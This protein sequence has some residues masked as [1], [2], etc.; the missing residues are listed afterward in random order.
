MRP[1]RFSTAKRTSRLVTTKGF[2]LAPGAQ[3]VFSPTIGAL[4][5]GFRWSCNVRV[6]ANE[7]L[8]ESTGNVFI[9]DPTVPSAF[10]VA[11]GKCFNFVGSFGRH[12]ASFAYDGMTVDISKFTFTYLVI[13]RL[14]TRV[15]LHHGMVELQKGHEYSEKDTQ[16]RFE[17]GYK[18]M[19]NQYD[20]QRTSSDHKCK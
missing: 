6:I 3:G 8:P 15:L 5:P 1:N 11:V 17:D 19:L 2:L 14:S 16:T 4:R 13:S 12:L 7:R 18:I 20:G 9:D 10:A